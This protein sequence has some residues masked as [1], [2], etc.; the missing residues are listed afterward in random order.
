[1]KRNQ[2]QS[3]NRHKSYAN[4]KADMKRILSTHRWTSLRDSLQKLWQPNIKQK[5]E[6]EC[7]HN[8]QYLSE[9]DG[10]HSDRSR[11]GFFTAVVSLV[12]REELD[13]VAQQ[14]NLPLS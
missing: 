8:A 3:K 14:H 4:I 11:A 12:I 7:V 1:M 13:Q 10:G 6:V 5:T 9:Y 2:R